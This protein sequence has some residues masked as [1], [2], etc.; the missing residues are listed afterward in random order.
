MI[1]KIII[2]VFLYSAQA[3][4]AELA[5]GIRVVP[6]AVMRGAENPRNLFLTIP[7]DETADGRAQ[8]LDEN[9]EEPVSKL[10]IEIP[11]CTPTSPSIEELRYQMEEKNKRIEDFIRP[12]IRPGFLPSAHFVTTD[13]LGNRFF[14]YDFNGCIEG[15]DI[16]IMPFGFLRIGTQDYLFNPGTGYM[17]MPVP[18]SKEDIPSAMRVESFVDRKVEFLTRLIHKEPPEPLTVF[19]VGK[20]KATIKTG[21]MRI[22]GHRFFTHGDWV[23]SEILPDGTVIPD[24]TPI[25]KIFQY[26]LQM[27]DYDLETARIFHVKQRR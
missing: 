16:T 26:Y 11:P 14:S 2:A 22:D 18:L 15:V 25:S 8:R 24:V 1:K 7:K 23:L 12:A 21:E 19:K 4:S 10:H 6:K 17:I 3:N 13:P 20:F 27:E 9:R 5:E